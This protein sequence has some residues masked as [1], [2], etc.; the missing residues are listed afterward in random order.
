[1]V[2]A[3]GPRLSVV[4]SLDDWKT[5]TNSRP[6]LFPELQLDDDELTDDPFQVSSGPMGGQGKCQWASEGHRPM[7]CP[8]LFLLP[9][10][11][12]QLLLVP[13]LEPEGSGSSLWMVGAARTL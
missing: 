2:V 12:S 8:I 4:L 11:L 10:L 5:G 6:W 13:P 7:Q 1:M 9:G 3:C